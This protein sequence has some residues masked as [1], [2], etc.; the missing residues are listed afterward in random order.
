MLSSRC[1]L[2]PPRPPG[3]R[4]LPLPKPPASMSGC[5]HISMIIA[6]MVEPRW[7]GGGGFGGRQPPS[8]GGLGGGATPKSEIRR[9]VLWS[10]GESWVFNLKCRPCGRAS[11]FMASTGTVTININQASAEID[12][13]HYGRISVIS[14]LAWFVLVVIVPVKALTCIGGKQKF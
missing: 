5:L 14:A 2:Q 7:F 10:P 13:I 3:F 12:Q 4:G 1:V 6:C 8:P 11:V 9:A